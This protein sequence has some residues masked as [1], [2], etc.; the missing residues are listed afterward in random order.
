MSLTQE[1]QTVEKP[2]HPLKDGRWVRVTVH[3]RNDK[4][5]EVREYESHEILGLGEESPSDFIWTEGNFSCDCNRYLFFQRAK[6]ESEDERGCGEEGYSVRLT[7]PVTGRVY[8]D[9]I[10]YLCVCGHQKGQHR[11]FADHDEC[12]DCVATEGADNDGLCCEFRPA[13]PLH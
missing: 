11:P 9:E 4:T 12:L 8:Y 1:W 5:G 3:I 10:R 6:G 7:N 13:R 2:S